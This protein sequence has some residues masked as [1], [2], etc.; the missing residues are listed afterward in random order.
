L[1]VVF[2]V[3]VVVYV[4][5][6]YAHHQNK[7]H[8][9]NNAPLVPAYLSFRNNYIFIYCLMMAG[10]WL[11]GPYVYVVY[12]LYGFTVKE[13]GILFILGFASSL[14]FGTIVGSLADRIGRKKACLLYCVI[15][16]CGCMT[17]HFNNMAI[18]MIGRIC[19]GISTSLLFSAFESW[20]IAEATKQGF[21]GVLL[22]DIF[23]K[24]VFF[25][26][27]LT[28][29][30][31]GL[32]SNIL[33][34]SYGVIVPFDFAA[35][36]LVVGGCCIFA[37]WP[38]N[39]G[40]KNDRTLLSQFNVAFNAIQKDSR[41]LLLGCI[42][43]L[44]EGAMYTFVFLWTPAMSKGG[45]QIAHGHV[46]ANFMLSCMVGSA[47][48]GNLMTSSV[49]P[50][51]YMQ[52]AF[53]VAAVCM[54]FTS[55]IYDFI[56]LSQ[57]SPSFASNVCFILFCTFE[58]VVGIF[59]P[60]MMKMRSQ[61]IPEEVRSTVMNLFRIPLNIFVCSVLYHV[62]ENNLGIMFLVCSFFLTCACLCQIRLLQIISS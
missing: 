20:L 58:V 61:Y 32:L 22:G 12:E 23:S 51:W 48:A 37:Y 62:T 38:E 3:L 19:G 53:A 14:V 16:T 31:A 41:V 55:L 21:Q 52:F 59:W 47:I 42:Q 10:D 50:E 8:D 15:Y 11:Q 26:N 39:Y 60:S 57:F 7:D 54:F 4:V 28:A 1:L 49:L 9:H 25:G 36:L 17:K 29:I 45:I 35:L 34:R 40:T 13:I 44:F 43:A 33:V 2:V 5:V 30:V 56:S 24:A 6:E 27:G 18:L 46:F